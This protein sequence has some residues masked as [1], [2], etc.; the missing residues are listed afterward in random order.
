MVIAV[1][2][3]VDLINEIL[4]DQRTTGKRHGKRMGLLVELAR[5]N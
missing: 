1:F 5:A 2:H 4:I 3:S